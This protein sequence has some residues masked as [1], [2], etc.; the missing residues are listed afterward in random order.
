MM[1]HERDGMKNVS[2]GLVM[3]AA[4]VS[5]TALGAEELVQKAQ[6]V[7]FDAGADVRFRY[8]FKDNWMDKG[9]TSISPS[10]EDYYRMRTRV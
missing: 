4:F 2:V 5:A 8:E 10:Y 1:N 7:D 6:G 3:A 9:K